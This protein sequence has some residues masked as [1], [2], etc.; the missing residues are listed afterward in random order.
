MGMVVRVGFDE[1]SPE[2]PDPAEPVH[3]LHPWRE[4][5]WIF[6]D[7]GAVTIERR[8]DHTRRTA[9]VSHLREE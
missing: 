7:D 5:G 8:G 6:T 1:T 3:E 4:A 9:R 2:R